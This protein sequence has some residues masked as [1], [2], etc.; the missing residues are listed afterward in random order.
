VA[1]ET[2]A[3]KLFYDLVRLRLE[4]LRLLTLVDERALLSRAVA[5]LRLALSDARGLLLRAAADV[6]ALVESVEQARV[7]EYLR[8]SAD[9]RGRVRA[10]D[11]QAAALLAAPWRKAAGREG[12][13]ARMAQDI[14]AAAGLRRQSVILGL[15]PGPQSWWTTAPRYAA[16]PPSVKAAWR[17]VR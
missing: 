14:A 5:D 1:E 6:G 15:L 12:D 17:T 8:R 4:G 16:A 2:R 7:A 3:E 13:G 11:L 9:D 10:A